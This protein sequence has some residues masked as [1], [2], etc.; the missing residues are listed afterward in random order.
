MGVLFRF[1]IQKPWNLEPPY[2]CTIHMFTFR[3]HVLTRPNPF[4]TALADLLSPVDCSSSHSLTN[5]T[6]VIDSDWFLAKKQSQPIRL[7][8][9]ITWQQNHDITYI[10]NHTFQGISETRTNWR[11]IPIVNI[12][13]HLP[14]KDT[15]SH[16]T[17]TQ[18]H[19]HL[20]Y[21]W[22]RMYIS[23]VLS[24]PQQRSVPCS[25]WS[26]FYL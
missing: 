1:W 4:I 24:Q 5:L 3:L 25:V 11:R 7:S 2:H 20:L 13:F 6:M 19:S 22:K 12:V 9:R 10:Q 15:Q 14:R 26:M 23:R 16:L 21:N 18:L 17:L 8:I